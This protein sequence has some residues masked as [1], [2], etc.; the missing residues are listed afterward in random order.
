[1]TDSFELSGKEILAALEYVY[2]ERFKDKQA[3]LEFEVPRGGD[4]SGMIIDLT[5]PDHKLKITL[6]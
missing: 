4:Y 5:D 2:P 1:M 6:R 3:T